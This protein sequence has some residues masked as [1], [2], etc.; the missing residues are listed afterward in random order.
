MPKKI[1]VPGPKVSKTGLLMKYIFHFGPEEENLKA[2]L[3]SFLSNL[4][5]TKIVYRCG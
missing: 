5:G 2:L 4:K 3:Y 1:E